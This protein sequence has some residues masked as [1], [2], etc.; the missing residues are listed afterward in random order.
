MAD[1]SYKV[2]KYTGD[3]NDV[4]SS[5]RQIS[6]AND[7]MSKSLGSNFQKGFNDI[8]D[9]LNKIGNVKIE[10]IGSQFAHL[11]GT[12]STTSKKI[13]DINGNF[14][15]L[16]TTVKITSK[17]LGDNIKY[18]RTTTTSLKELASVQKEATIAQDPMIGKS[19]QLGTNFNKLSSITNNFS[20]Q[21]SSV[22]GASKVM[23]NS[24]NEISDSGSKMGYVIQ[25]ANGKFFELR[26]TIKRTPE[27]IQKVTRN[28]K[29]VTK[30]YAENAT[31]AKGTNDGTVSLTQNMARLASRAALTIPL[32]LAL[33]SVMTTVF[34][35]IKSGI[36]TLF[37]F[38]KALQKLRKNLQGT[39]AQVD[40][41]FNSA[42]KTIKEFSLESGLSVEKVTNA[43][44]KFATVGFDF[45]T[46][47]KAGLDAAK[48]SIILFGDAEETAT[49][50]SRGLRA[51]VT[52]SK[53][54]KKSQ[55]EIASAMA[56]TSDLWATNAF[57]ISELSQGLQ[58]FSA[59]AKSMN[60]TVEE[61]ITLLAA[62]GTQGLNTNRAGTLL[63][64]TSQKLEQNL[65][66][67]AK[68]LGI[69]VN[70]EV[71]R[72]FDVFRRVTQAIADL[73]SE[74]GTISPR[75]TEAI[76]ELFGGVK[77]GE[78]IR[79]LISDM[80]TVNST[81]DQ[82][83]SKSGNISKFNK[84]YEN[85]N[86]KLFQQK[87]I[88]GRVKNAIGTA[89]VEGV[90][91]GDAF[92]DSL[93]DINSTLKDMIAPTKELGS[94]LGLALKI[95]GEAVGPIL[96]LLSLPAN[97]NADL[98][99][100]KGVMTDVGKAL[101]GDLTNLE[102]EKVIVDYKKAKVLYPKSKKLI[103]RLEN[104]LPKDYKYTLNTE[105]D[106][107]L[108]TI[109]SQ[110]LEEDRLVLANATIQAELEKYKL[111]G[112]SNSEL[113]KTE[114]ILNKTL[115]V[116]QTEEQILTRKLKLEQ[117]INNEKRLQGKLG[118]DS[119]KLYQISKE[120]GVD[121]A[122]QIN[123]ALSGEIDFSSFVRRGGE[124][125]EVFKKEFAGIFEQ[126]QAEAFFKGST[127]KGLNEL[128]GGRGINIQEKSVQDPGYI[129]RQLLRNKDITASESQLLARKTGANVGT[130]LGQT[131]P[132]VNNTNSINVNIQIDA[133]NAD[134]SN[135]FR[136]TLQNAVTKMFSNAQFK[137][138]LANTV[139][140]DKQTNNF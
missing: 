119:L 126:K 57:E 107:K 82:Y 128:R 88:L 81:L 63:R 92:A 19:S 41:N 103:K 113:L 77:G 46:S 137:K 124:A 75:V 27:G 69:K 94:V 83:A 5:I 42:K 53:D 89:F 99:N 64:T 110:V 17:G 2:V 78:P 16:I 36:D 136:N 74:S 18:F 84:D 49:A 20:K 98:K 70:P 106:T 93:K 68:V 65:S 114:S 47:M 122:K 12:T 51:L 32:W 13:K 45:D 116:Y 61:T 97:M 140:H 9:S 24:I 4:L 25:T 76:S 117:E 31:V 39:S 50:Y 21:L 102:I 91:G 23:G 58:K 132:Q 22:G 11:A 79:A 1:Q 105:V 125:V 6:A 135:Q 66:K 60:F 48:L 35:T 86:E 67:V 62:L 3:I 138:V 118:S 87:E 90:T 130:I 111:L 55:K 30:Q 131:A 133:M 129:Q 29:E 54:T 33:R 43:I 59:T 40:T 38:D 26:E 80:K 95:L 8:G 104:L 127:V 56:L 52:D 101:K 72:T 44:Q 121:I 10:K 109:K 96:K 134:N 112:A 120:S 123:D 15:N 71:D 7:K 139:F 100:F 14:A 115:N 37:N 85:I 108:D 73:K 28:M 34:S